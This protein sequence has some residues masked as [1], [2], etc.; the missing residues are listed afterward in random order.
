M[1][2]EHQTKRNP[3]STF[4]DKVSENFANVTRKLLATDLFSKVALYIDIQNTKF[5]YFR[6]SVIVNECIVAHDKLQNVKIFRYLFDKLIKT[7][8][9]KAEQPPVICKN[10][11][12]N[13]LP[14]AISQMVRRA[15]VGNITLPPIVVAETKAKSSIGTPLY[16]PFRFMEHYNTPKAIAYLG[17]H[18]SGQETPSNREYRHWLWLNNCNYGNGR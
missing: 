5:P 13:S 3:Y 11:Y 15:M 17:N 9:K 4:S 6:K 10:L 12:T 14:G 2:Q 18:I 1:A 16:H 8:Y 7:K